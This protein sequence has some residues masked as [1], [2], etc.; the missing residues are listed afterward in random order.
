MLLTE[1]FNSPFK[2]VS[3]QMFTNPI[4]KIRHTYKTKIMYDTTTKEE[5]LEVCKMHFDRYVSLYKNYAIDG[6]QATESSYR[7]R[8]GVLENNEITYKHIYSI[9]YDNIADR[10]CWENKYDENFTI[11]G[12]FSIVLDVNADVLP[13][14]GPD[15]DEE[16]SL[17]PPTNAIKESLCVV[18]YENKPNILY[19]ECLHLVSCES[20]DTKGKFSKCPLCRT[21][22][23]NKKIRI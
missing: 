3:T 6:V 17:S 19:T 8:V 7:L 14:Y 4:P 10:I 20:C 15:D 18:C 13:D 5:I 9:Y 1:V 11:E 21:K 23:K 2:L 22:I 12:T 16:D